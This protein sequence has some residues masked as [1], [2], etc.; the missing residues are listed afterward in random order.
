MDIGD[1]GG[2]IHLE[3]SIPRPQQEFDGSKV[4]LVH[5]SVPPELSP[6][7]LVREI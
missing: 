2:R 6:V 1:A 3:L 7:T 5:V 4:F